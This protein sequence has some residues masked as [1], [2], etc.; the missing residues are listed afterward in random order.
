MPHTTNPPY[1]NEWRNHIPST[2]AS[3]Y[4]L[5][6]RGLARIEH[7]CFWQLTDEGKKELTM[8]TIAAA[9]KKP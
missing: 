6:K 8:T 1:C 7:D 4:A 3:F 5:K 2:P 9:T